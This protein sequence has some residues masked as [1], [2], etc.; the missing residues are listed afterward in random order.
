[1]QSELQGQKWDLHVS[2]IPNWRLLWLFQYESSPVKISFV[3]MEALAVMTTKM[4][5]YITVAAQ[6]VIAEK[7]AK[8]SFPNDL[9]KL[10]H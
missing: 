5:H 1:M 9:F 10:Y 2:K 4:F 8:V 6:A 7:T 3:L